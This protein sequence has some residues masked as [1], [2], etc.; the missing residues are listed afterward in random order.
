MHDFLLSVF[1]PETQSII[2]FW[3]LIGG[4]VGGLLIIWKA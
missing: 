1:S 4:V 2:G 3:I